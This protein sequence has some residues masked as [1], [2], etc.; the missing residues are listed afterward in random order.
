MA[1]VDLP[2][3]FPNSK[4]AG[5]VKQGQSRFIS[6]DVAGTLLARSVDAGQLPTAPNAPEQPDA[7]PLNR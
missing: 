3:Q 2:G 7:L 5:A 4:M 6:V 1:D